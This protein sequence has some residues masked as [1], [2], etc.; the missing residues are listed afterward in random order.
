MTHLDKRLRIDAAPQRACGRLVLCVKAEDG[1]TRLKDVRQE[2]SFR[3]LFPRQHDKTIQ[4]VML[5]TA[6]GIT[7]GDQ[8]AISAK[9]GEGTRLTLT[10][11]AAERV[12]RA[13]GQDAGRFKSDLCVAQDAILHWL[14]QETILF[15]GSCFQRTLS[16][17]LA[18][19]AAFLMCEPLVFGRISSA[20]VIHRAMFDDRVQI[21]RAGRLIY[22]DAVRL[23]GD[24]HAQLQRSAL[25]NGAGAMASVVLCAANAAQ[26]LDPIRALLPQTAGASLLAQDLLTIRLLAP[27]S[28]ILRQTL[29]PVLMRLTQNALPKTWRL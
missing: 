9:A 24:I 29:C 6:G 22:H 28:F 14:P 5:N 2:G 16:V 19:G 27:D 1:Q 15:D 12:Y 17:D 26:Y 10:T 3:L 21:R 20:E 23:K 8:F 7:G 18:P 13:V 4:A 25:A 11:Q